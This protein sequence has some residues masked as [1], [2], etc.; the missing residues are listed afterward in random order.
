MMPSYLCYAPSISVLMDNYREVHRTLTSLSTLSTSTTRRLDYTYY[1]LLSHLSA[2]TATISDLSVLSSTTVRLAQAFSTESKD[3]IQRTSHQISAFEDFEAQ[4][5]RIGALQERMEKGRKSVGVLGERLERVRGKV[6]ACDR[7]EEEWKARM[8][9]RVRW[10][11][12]CSCMILGV[13]VLLLIIRHWPRA[14]E[15]VV[16]PVVGLGN[17][18]VSGNVALPAIKSVASG[19][20][21]GGRIAGSRM[22]RLDVDDHPALRLLDEL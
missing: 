10:L 12:G 11:W 16:P 7:M 2:L 3:I 21:E 17:L 22:G 15:I 14:K 1:S 18:T 9:R 13:V 19:R 6:E 4:R 20:E 5:T 8:G